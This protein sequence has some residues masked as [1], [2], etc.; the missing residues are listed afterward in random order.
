[1]RELNDKTR[2]IFTTG[3]VFSALGKGIA[4]SSIGALL[5]NLSFKVLN[6]K[7]DP[8]LN[9]DA[10]TM[11]PYQHGEVFVTQDGKETDLDIGNYERF[12]NQNL[13]K[14]SNITSGL[15]Y[16]NV[17]NEERNGKYLGKTIQVIP[18]ITDAIK[19]EIIFMA[20]KHEPDFLIVEIGGTVGDIESVPFIESA[21]QLISKYKN[22]IFSV[23]IVPIIQM[24]TSNEEKTKPLQHSVKELM[25]MGI[26]PDVL[27]VRGKGIV[28]EEN[29]EKISLICGLDK[30][31]II[32][33]PN[34][35]SVYFLPEFLL[36]Q[37]LHNIIFN[38][39][40]LEE[41]NS[42]DLGEWSIFTSKIKEPKKYV[43]KIAIIGKYTEITDA[44][45]SVITSLEIAAIHNNSEIKIDLIN[46]EKI[47]ESNV[48]GL[49]RYSG[50]VVP[51][52]FGDR[53]IEGKIETIK[54]VREN[55]IPFLGICL[56]MQL[57]A[58]EFARNVLGIVDANS[59]EFDDN[60][61]EPIITILDGKYKEKDLGGTLRLGN[62]SCAIKKDTK[63]FEAYQDSIVFER[64]RHRYEFN[65][66]YRDI[67][68]LN[69]VIFSGVNVENDLVEIIELQDHKFFIATQFHPELTTKTFTPNPLFNS[70]VEVT[71]ELKNK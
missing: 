12:L 27:L 55:N 23:H 39:M 60:T 67:F 6:M 46:A 51:G 70:F 37:N 65:N 40:D 64:H 20:N 59:T 50:V 19:N 34:Q 68:E 25:G 14:E 44:Y 8:Y 7:L 35:T 32:S 56:G 48:R 10:G 9:I 54:F 57:A 13:P 61:I 26:I 66:D 62:Y 22:K 63:T 3:G 31:N 38:K 2:I 29:K 36:E 24:L 28:S 53:G 71:K 5:K 43:T 49:K 1:M 69:G 47:N 45:L 4:C 58:I 21:R 11:S 18:H 41:M 33:L 42:K 52:G 17:L 15:I 30:N 16:S